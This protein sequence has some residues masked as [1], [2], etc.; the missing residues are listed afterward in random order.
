M[1][2]LMDSVSQYDAGL[3]CCSN[4][5]IFA[6]GAL[7]LGMDLRVNQTLRILVVSADLL[8]WG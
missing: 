4:N 5:R 7:S 2:T 1:D 3:L 6:A 8:W